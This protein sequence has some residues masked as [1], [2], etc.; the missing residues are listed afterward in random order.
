M[1][2]DASLPEEVVHLPFEDGPFRMAMGLVACPEA[3]WFEIDARYPAEMAERRELLATR[4]AD[5]L[6]VVPGSEAARAETLAVLAAH[7]PRHHPAWFRRDGQILHNRL[8]GERW[9]LAAPPCDPLELAGR[10]VQ[11]DLCL[12][13]PEADGPVL[14]AG[15]VCAPSRWRLTE[16]VGH[17]LLQVHA[18]VP[19][20]AERLGAPVDRFMHHLKE[21]RI[22]SRMNWSVVDS[23][24]LFQLGGKHRTERDPGITAANAGEKLHLRT[25]RQSFRRLPSTGRVLFGIRVHS[26]PLARIAAIPGAAARLAAAVRALPAEMGRY[27]SLPVYREALLGF[28]DAAASRTLG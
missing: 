3:A 12:I 7:L 21:G 17:P 9:D 18:P 28:L 8:T 27:K 11:E 2:C 25:E 19:L 10:L 24:A 22:A 15:L 26:Y 13:R 5:V 16:K 1:E 23:P 6:A 20:Y 14:E 4:R